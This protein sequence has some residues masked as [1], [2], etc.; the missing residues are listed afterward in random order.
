MSNSQTRHHWSCTASVTAEIERIARGDPNDKET[1]PGIPGV[2]HTITIPGTSVIQN[3]NGS[4]FGTMFVVL[5]EF[6][7]RHNT[8]LSGDAIT[9]K[10]RVE[11]FRRVEGELRSPCSRHR[12]WTVLGKRWRLPVRWSATEPLRV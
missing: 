1:Y 5:D 11:F 3:A 6:K 7:N 8:D 10:L 9:R 4:N 2:S 12:L